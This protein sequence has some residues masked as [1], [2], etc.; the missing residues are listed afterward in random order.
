MWGIT[1]LSGLDLGETRIPRFCMRLECTILA[2]LELHFQCF[3]PGTYVVSLKN[4]IFLIGPIQACYQ[5]RS[6]PAGVEALIPIP[7]ATYWCIA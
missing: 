4:K 2:L 3:L 7:T 6:K 5:A 1:T